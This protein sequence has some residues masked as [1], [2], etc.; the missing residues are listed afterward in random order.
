MVSSKLYTSLVFVLSGQCVVAVLNSLFLLSD[1]Q[2]TA[3]A[4]LGF[5]GVHRAHEQPQVL[6]LFMS[7]QVLSIVI[8]MAKGE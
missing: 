4:L 7:L 6:L 8:D 5:Y 2:S 1:G 3:L